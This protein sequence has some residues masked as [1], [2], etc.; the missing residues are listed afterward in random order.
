[1]EASA[2]GLGFVEIFLLLFSGQLLGLVPGERDP[3]LIKSPPA[4]AY[5]Y[6]E[7]TALG[8]TELGAPGVAGM[9][10]DPEIEAFLT[11][12]AK[13]VAASEADESGSFGEIEATTRAELMT[14]LR[15]TAA[16]AGCI[17]VSGD[18]PRDDVAALI[19]LE[20]ALVLNL[21][22]DADA[23]ESSLNELL[24]H[25]P[26]YAPV[27]NPQFHPIPLAGL[28]AELHREDN[29][30]IVSVGNGALQ[31]LL[32]RRQKPVAELPKSSRFTAAWKAA[33]TE[34]MG[35]FS[36]VD[37][38]TLREEL[39]TRHGPVQGLIALGVIQALG[40]GDLNTILT[41]SGSDGPDSRVE[42]RVA[43]GD[44]QTGVL[45]LLGGRGLTKADFAHVPA[46]ADF[47]AAVSLDLERVLST[48]R[49]IVQKTAP[50]V[51]AGFDEFQRQ[52]EQELKL[53]TDDITAA[54]GE[55]ITAYDAPSTGGLGIAGL[56]VA[57]PV[58][59]A[60]RAATVVE[61]LRQLIA[62][63][64]QPSGDDV[65]IS[66]TEIEFQSETIYYL[67]S[68]GHS[69]RYNGAPPWSPAF[70]LTKQS[71]LFALNPQA[72]KGH[73]RFA[74]SKEPR[75]AVESLLPAEGE[76]ISA[77]M[78]DTPKIAQTIWPVLPYLLKADFAEGQ[79]NGVP[80]KLGDLPSVRAV[81]PYLRRGSMIMV[82]RPNSVVIEQRNLLP[83][84]LAVSLLPR[85]ADSGE[86]FLIEDGE[87]PLG[88]KGA[89]VG[90]PAV[91]LGVGTGVEQAKA[92]APA[93][94]PKPEPTAVE[95]AALK[96]L[97]ALIKGLL[98]S[99]AGA[100]VPDTVIQQISAEMTPEKIEERRVE[101]ERRKAERAVK[102]AARKV[103]VD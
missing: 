76:T 43:L 22:D 26:N 65:R 67:N 98:P 63:G 39:P 84:V 74:A 48:A 88:R 25:L 102:R 79:A 31:R 81:V 90:A 53:N 87:V 21:G 80:L 89:P 23:F 11:T 1:M 3:E 4:G 83:L 58:Q 18:I 37:L 71:L 19:R 8:P 50:D 51:L 20:G 73:L 103:R 68:S 29:T 17:Y 42:T 100:F 40:L 47:V 15:L 9:L 24:K 85:M 38:A 5:F 33:G 44:Q 95:R 75:F 57:L 60:Q 46:D 66:L 82:R 101:R 62:E 32:A 7:W 28:P 77:M 36:W 41:V 30:M 10:A 27:H 12:L 52:L 72:I 34:R 69:V 35:Q 78:I 93:P 16:H 86:E 61:R 94:K 96:S 91:N 6:Q 55:T 45:R 59:D 2:V 13:A 64:I 56:I 92:E 14:L 99:Q 49:E 54:F 70:C 97:P